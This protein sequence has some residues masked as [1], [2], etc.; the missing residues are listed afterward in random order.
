MKYV[1]EKHKENKQKLIS[2]HLRVLKSH[3]FDFSFKVMNILNLEKFFVYVLKFL[4]F[5]FKF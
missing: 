4:E 5:D 1:G 2:G 3:I